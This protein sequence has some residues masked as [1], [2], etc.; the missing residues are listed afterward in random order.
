MQSDGETRTWQSFN[1]PI[2]AEE[3]SEQAS[4]DREQASLWAWAVMLDVKR[5]YSTLLRFSRQSVGT[6]YAISYYSQVSEVVDHCSSQF[7]RFSTLQ[8]INI[9]DPLHS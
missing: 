9:L 1:T 3:V 5:K 7:S 8:Y 2:T 4:A 6:Q